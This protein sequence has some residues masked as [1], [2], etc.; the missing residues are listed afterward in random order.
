[1]KSPIAIFSS[2]L[3]ILSIPVGIVT[4]PGFVKAEPEPLS[5]AK[6]EG[7]LQVEVGA[8]PSPRIPLAHSLGVT[9]NFFPSGQTVQNVW[10]DN[11]TW[12]VVDFDGC[13]SYRQTSASP[14]ESQAPE[15]C[16][17]PARTSVV[18][19]RRIEPLN[20]SGLAPTDTSLLTVVSKDTAGKVSIS[21]YQLVKSNTAS[22]SVVEILK[23]TPRCQQ[24]R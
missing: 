24:T 12:V 5:K 13:L 20:I 8:T 9:L 17:A 19:L 15:T 18:H 3:L 10:I 4:V 1:M 11:P 21:T 16:K 23:P 2:W 14:K 6:Q 7:I 22:F